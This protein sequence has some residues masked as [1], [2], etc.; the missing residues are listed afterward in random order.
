MKMFRRRISGEKGA[1]RVLHVKVFAQFKVHGKLEENV[2]K[3]KRVQ[4]K[5]FE[6]NNGTYLANVFGA[7]GKSCGA[8]PDDGRSFFIVFGSDGLDELVFDR[9]TKLRDDNLGIKCCC[10]NKVVCLN[11]EFVC[12][13]CDN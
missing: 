3:R 6:R 10:E 13:V 1:R 5:S 2:L 4:L 8:S 12:L 9:E 11:E 7:S